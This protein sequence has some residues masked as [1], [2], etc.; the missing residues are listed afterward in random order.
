MCIYIYICTYTYIYNWT[1]QRF[2]GHFTGNPHIEVKKPGFPVD[3]SF[4]QSTG[5]SV[6]Q[7]WNSWRGQTSASKICKSFH[8][9]SLLHPFNV[10]ASQGTILT[11]KW[12]Q[13]EWHRQVL[14]GSTAQQECYFMLGELQAEPATNSCCQFTGYKQCWRS[15]HRFFPAVR[16]V[17]RRNAVEDW[18]ADILMF[19]RRRHNS[20]CIRNSTGL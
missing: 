6:W 10:S 19:Q 15:F 17:A 14:S 20:K 4:G 1:S 3:S 8:C 7:L 2:T 5:I 12:L 9:F 13:M 18:V 11:C 16:Y